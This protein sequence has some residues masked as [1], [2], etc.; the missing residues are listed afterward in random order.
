MM[1]TV[2]AFAIIAAVTLAAPA[3]V[4]AQT[5]KGLQPTGRGLAT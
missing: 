4:A 2:R 5:P 1:T 3:I